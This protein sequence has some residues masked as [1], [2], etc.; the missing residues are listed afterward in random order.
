MA[1]TQNKTN[2]K[3]V[4]IYNSLLLYDV[5][6]ILFRLPFCFHVFLHFYKHFVVD[7]KMGSF[8][9]SNQ[10]NFSIFHGHVQP[11]AIKEGQSWWP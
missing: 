10:C 5:F 7:M 11:K 9:A 2:K 6:L 1:T 3:C 8:D 4:I